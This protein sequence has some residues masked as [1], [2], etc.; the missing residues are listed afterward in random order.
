MTKPINDYLAENVETLRDQGFGE[1]QIADGM[2]SFGILLGEKIHG[3]RR[4]A[5]RL[6]LLAVNL[7]RELER[8]FAQR[9]DH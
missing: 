1:D 4:M 5:H 2:L 9:K 3:P 7:M 6:Y 8:A